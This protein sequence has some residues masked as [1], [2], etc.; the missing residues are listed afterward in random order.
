MTAQFLGCKGDSVKTKGSLAETNM[1][2]HLHEHDRNLTQPFG[3]AVLDKSKNLFVFFDAGMILFDLDWDHF[4]SRVCALYKT[5]GVSLTAF[6]RFLNE[7]R[8][9]QN[10]ERGLTGPAA[11]CEGF[12]E[13]LKA[14][15]TRPGTLLLTR[16]DPLVIKDLSSSIIGPLRPAVLD[17]ALTLRDCGVATGILS[18]ATAWHEADLL[19]QCNLRTHF[20]A[21]IFSQDFGLAKPDPAFYAVATK[22]AHS[23][24]KCTDVQIIFVDDTPNNVREACVA[25]WEARMPNLL[26]NQD[27]W[28]D[29]ALS[30]LSQHKQNLVFQSV[31]AGRVLELFSLLL[32]PLHNRARKSGAQSTPPPS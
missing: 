32:D 4:A 2:P 8:V 9:M 25:G 13:A 6:R 10:W 16:P 7:H 24:I 15:Q 5:G 20:D 23:I 29:Q 22:V 14:A 21:V 19:L 30:D 27:H 26:A 17:L 12:Y 31:A 18:N 28:H 3:S 11:F 1:W